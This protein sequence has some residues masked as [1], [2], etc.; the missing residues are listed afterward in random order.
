MSSVGSSSNAR[1]FGNHPEFAVGNESVS[2]VK[3]LL[4]DSTA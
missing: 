1:V 2:E 3:V 4:G